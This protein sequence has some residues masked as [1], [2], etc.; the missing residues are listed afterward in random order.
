MSYYLGIDI[1]S[2]S[3]EA[4]IIDDDGSITSVAI[5][6]SGAKHAE[7]INRAVS[8]ALDKGG[9]SEGNI[10]HIVSTG[11]GRMLVENR[12]KDM[13]EITCHGRGM[14]YYKPDTKVIID[15]GGQ[16]SKVIKIENNQVVNFIMNDKCAAGTGRFI[17]AMARVLE[18]DIDTYADLD[19]GAVGSQNISSMCAV[20]AESEVVGLAAQGIEI[21]EIVSGLNR[22]I[23]SRTLSLV[24]RVA[25]DLRQAN[26]SMSGGV[27]YNQGVIRAFEKMFNT[28]IFIPPSPDIIGALGAAL[29]AR[30]CE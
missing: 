20:F 1:G 19:I 27:A 17:E 28:R 7:A 18:V 29:L 23:A 4:V 24:K 26:L 11:Y 3:C 25:P 8:E 6:P 9:I 10:K 15:I 12:S 14:L 30:E 2:L 16:D 21:K 5:T 13:T 22:S